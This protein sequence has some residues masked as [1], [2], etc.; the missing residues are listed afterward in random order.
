[1]TF[2]D[3]VRLVWSA[4][5]SIVKILYFLNRIVACALVVVDLYCE[6]YH[7]VALELSA[8]FSTQCCLGRRIPMSVLPLNASERALK[9][10]HQQ[11]LQ[12]LVQSHGALVS[13]THSY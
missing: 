12:A 8:Y 11:V 5:M 2:D 3:E 1:M 7:A 4:R 13:H 10:N 6:F 9:E